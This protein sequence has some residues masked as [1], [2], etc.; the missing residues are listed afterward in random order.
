TGDRQADIA[1]GV[2]AITRFIED[3]VRESPV[4]WFWVHKRWPDRVYA[5]LEP[6]RASSAT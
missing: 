2:Q 3:R 5:A 4:D 6:P 1:R